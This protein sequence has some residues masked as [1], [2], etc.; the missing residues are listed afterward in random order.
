MSCK[1]A[2]S[3]TG[4]CLS[5]PINVLSGAAVAGSTRASL[6]SSRTVSFGAV[7]NVSSIPAGAELLV[8]CDADTAFRDAA[9][10]FGPQK[11][12]SQVQIAALTERLDA[13]A[14]YYLDKFGIDVSILPGAGAAG[15]L[16]GGMLALGGTL[17][18]GV[19]YVA[20]ALSLDTALDRADF[21]LTGEGMMDR[22]SFEGKVIGGS[23]RGRGLKTSNWGPSLAL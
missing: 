7:Q 10:D 2:A 4:D 14:A 23:R 19:D 9:R 1:P 20:D 11:G 17:L 21:V 8:V 3:Y 6:E 18:R 5:I 13:A 12:A 16:A 22:L 15:G